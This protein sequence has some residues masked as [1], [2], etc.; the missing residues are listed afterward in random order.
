MSLDFSAGGENPDIDTS[1]DDPARRIYKI[2]LKETHTRVLWTFERDSENVRCKI[3]LSSRYYLF[4][5]LE[6]MLENNTFSIDKY[7]KAVTMTTWEILENYPET[8]N[9]A[10]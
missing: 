2:W 9:S 5:R 1:D 3:Y 6:M 10:W 8:Q 7:R 4:S